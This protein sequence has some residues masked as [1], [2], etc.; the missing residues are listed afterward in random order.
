MIRGSIVALITPFTRT[1][2][3][4]RETC[5]DL[6]RFHAVRGTDAVLLAGT[7]GESPTLD[8]R[9][10][11]SFVELALEE[12]GSKMGLVLGCGANST[13]TA[14]SLTRRAKELGADFGLSV[15]PYYNK[16]TQEGLYRHFMEVADVGLPIILYNV[17]GRT[18]VNL[19]PATVERLSHH[20]NIVAIKEASGDMSQIQEVARLKGDRLS[21]LS[22]DDALTFDVV[23][24]G[25]SGVI[26]VTANLLPGPVREVVTMGLQGS[27]EKARSL[28]HNLLP[29]HRAMFIETNPSPV[30]AA[31]NLIGWSVGKPRLPLVALTKKGR[32]FLGKLLSR[33]EQRIREEHADFVEPVF[34]GREK[35]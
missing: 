32:A 23:C 24:G 27:V 25:G 10:K 31:M 2:A 9:E 15:C 3:L 1:G 22:G 13:K 16:P 14:V 34:P 26:S 19:E 8:T 12:R 4:D 21:L 35:T 7:T 17:P 29:L 11:E 30:K 18:S 33:Y 5:R 20:D 6:I 28:H